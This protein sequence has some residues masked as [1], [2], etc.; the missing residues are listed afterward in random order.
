MC[1]SSSLILISAV[2][3]DLKMPPV[4]PNV[5]LFLPLSLVEQQF[6]V[7]CL[8]HISNSKYARCC[9]VGNHCNETSHAAILS[10]I[11]THKILYLVLSPLFGFFDRQ[12]TRR[13]EEGSQQR[14]CELVFGELYFPSLLSSLVLCMWHLCRATA[15]KLCAVLRT[16]NCA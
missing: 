7:I 13:T 8:A 4:Y 14:P 10:T 2:V 6:V 12:R 5:A 1:F 15:H 9:F 16:G 3:G 11:I